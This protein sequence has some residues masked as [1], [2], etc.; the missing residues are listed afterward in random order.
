MLEHRETRVSF[1]KK[2]IVLEDVLDATN[3]ILDALASLQDMKLLAEEYEWDDM[4]IMLRGPTLTINLQQSC[5]I[6]QQAKD[7]LSMDARQEIGFDWGSCAWRKCGAQADAQE[8][9]AELYNA[10]G[11]FE[12]FECL[13]TIDIVERSLRDI[14][15]SDST[16][17]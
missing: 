14:F 4:R 15:I 11:L 10:I 1:W 8:S 12:P 17:L 7:F 16:R 6:L 2:D 5:S 9:L 3:G 13:F